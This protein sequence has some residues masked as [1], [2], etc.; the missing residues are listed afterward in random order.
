MNENNSL[1]ADVA[2]MRKQLNEMYTAMVG[3]PI[4]KDGGLVKRMADMEAAQDEQGGRLKK[5]ETALVKVA[6]YMKLFWAATGSAATAIFSLII[7]K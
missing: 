6:I 4:T 3:N 2:H 1:A 7:K 5:L